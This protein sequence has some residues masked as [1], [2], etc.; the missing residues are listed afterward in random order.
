MAKKKKDKNAKRFE[1]K[2]PVPHD[3]A[4]PEEVVA[5]P[6]PLDPAKITPCPAGLVSIECI[7][8]RYEGW[9]GPYIV[10]TAAAGENLPEISADGHHCRV[11][12]DPPS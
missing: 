9:T 4:V 2:H 6:V 3:C 7:A 1:I 12:F 8:T 11:T 10:L 5:V